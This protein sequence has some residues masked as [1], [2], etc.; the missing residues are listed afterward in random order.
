MSF[1]VGDRLGRFEIL[2][3]LGAGGMGEVYRAHDPQL[4]RDVAIKVLPAEFSD[5]AGRRRRFEQEARLAGGLNHP[6]IL[7]VYDV[8]VEGGSLYIVTEVLEGETLSER[9]AAQPLPVRRAADY[10][11]QIARGLAAA[12]DRGVVHRDIKPGNLFVTADGWIKIL[13]FGLAKYLGPDS[14]DSTETVIVD[15]EPRTPVMGSVTYMSPEQARGRRLDHR[16]DIFSFGAVFYELLA[17]FAPFRRATP[18]ETLHAIL[19]DEPADLP[20]G[21]PAILPLE[22]L[23]RHCLEK[24]PEERFQ[25]VRDLIFDLESRQQ[26]TGPVAAAGGRGRVRTSALVVASLLC[27]IAAAGMGALVT[28]RWLT[29]SPDAPYRVRPI[30]SVFGLEE[31]SAIS[32]DGKMVAFTGVQGG[33]RQIFIRSLAEDPVRQVTDDEADHEAPRW[34]PNSSSLTYFSPAAPG[35]VQGTISK[36]P[37]LGGPAQRVISS[38]GGGDVSSTG[39]LVCFRLEQDRIQLVT[40]TLDGSDITPIASLETQHYGYPR[41]SPDNQW[42]AFQAGDGFR[43]EVFVVP[44]KGGSTPEKITNDAKVIKG[45]TWLPDSRGVI[46]ASARAST[47]PYLP[48]LTLWE[49]RRDHRQRELTAPEASYEQP[50]LL[51]SGLL[52]VTR[53]QMRCNIWE[54]PFESVATAVERGRQVTRQTGQVATPTAAPDGD[55]VAYLSD[56]GGHANVWVTSKKGARQITFESDPEVAIGV[57]SWSP[58]GKWIAYLSSRG[59]VGLQ[60]GVWIVK[61]DTSEN[62]Q[63]VPKGLSPDWSDDGTW[64]YYV[65]TSNS[66]IQR[67]RVGGGAP[68][69]V[70]AEPARNL[71][72]VRGSTVYYVVDRALLD[73]RQQFE[74]W[75]ASLESGVAKPLSHLPIS[76]VPSWQ[77]VNPAL[78]PDGKWLAVPL[79]DGFTTNIW[80]ISTEDGRQMKRVT[81]FGDRAIFIP[82]RVAWSADGRS[83]LAAIGEGDAD[84]VLLDGLIKGISR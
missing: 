12:H 57:P 56:H 51:A 44:A 16:T 27:L 31:F 68:E 37:A 63:L 47:F 79:T 18:G 8:G 60:F 77:V 23:V 72:G 25:N 45:L 4:N 17:G 11:L 69:I 33:R 75:S 42:I 53:L 9:M 10:A 81:D 83:I 64:L 80:A 46:Y 55:Q 32:P 3:S 15:G 2:G 49:A 6:N 61:P 29:P 54:Y 84:I 19:H 66:P 59:N 20:H 24:K 22:R 39:R 73:G 13:D 82:R 52:S 38:I 67:I 65:E 50:D 58:D 1:A 78:S 35:E 36:I 70:R 43:W 7:A 76:R 21:D 26:D 5:D 40:S 71:I 48:P 30:T 28:A 74:I 14:S 62:H 41:W 34:L